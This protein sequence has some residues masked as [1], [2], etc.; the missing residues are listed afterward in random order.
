[1][2]NSDSTPVYEDLY[3]EDANKVEA[4]GWILMERFDLWKDKQNNPDPRNIVDII[5]S[6][7]IGAAAGLTSRCGI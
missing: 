4:I 1:M 5:V 7:I 3:S 6:I 2:I